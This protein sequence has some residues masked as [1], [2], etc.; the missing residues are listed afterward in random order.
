MACVMLFAFVPLDAALAQPVL[1]QI[2]PRVGDTLIVRLDQKIENLRVDFGLI[3]FDNE[4][5]LFHF[6][7]AGDAHRALQTRRQRTETNHPQAQ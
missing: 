3:A 6:L 1:L 5:D 2:R 4:F 7:L